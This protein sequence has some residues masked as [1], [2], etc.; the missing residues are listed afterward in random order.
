MRAV[1][2][3]VIAP[4]RACDI[5]DQEATQANFLSNT[6]EKPETKGKNIGWKY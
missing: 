6:T 3:K 1:A 5:I 4:L 2:K